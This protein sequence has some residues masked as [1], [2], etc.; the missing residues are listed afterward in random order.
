MRATRAR[1]RFFSAQEAA[2]VA[3]PLLTCAVA[4]AVAA[5]LLM[6]AVA[7]AV[8]APLLIC[9]VATRPYWPSSAKARTSWDARTPTT[10]LTRTATFSPDDQT[11]V[12]FQHSIDTRLGV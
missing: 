5:P 11:L 9:A 6:C 8:A 1:L 12:F 3:A 10:C 4:T 7:T 2:A